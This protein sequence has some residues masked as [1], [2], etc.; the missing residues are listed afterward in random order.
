MSSVVSVN[1]LQKKWRNI[2]DSYVRY[3]RAVRTNSGRKTWK[4]YIYAKNLEFLNSHITQSMDACSPGIKSEEESVEKADDGQVYDGSEASTM[5]SEGRVYK[6]FDDH[7]CHGG[8]SAS[9]FPLLQERYE[10]IDSCD[11]MNFFRSLLPMVRN[12]PM[13]DKLKFRVDVMNLLLENIKS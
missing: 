3:L 8:A 13:K 2:R 5:E 11:D 12:L 7:E 1:E 9:F 4:P 6:G 10:N